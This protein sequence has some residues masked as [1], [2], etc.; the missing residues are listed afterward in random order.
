MGR[1]YEIK[2]D[3]SKF[4]V[5]GRLRKSLMHWKQINAPQFV[6]ETIEF[7]YK[8][9]LLT[10]PPARIFRN[11]KSALLYMLEVLADLQAP[12]STLLCMFFWVVWA[13]SRTRNNIGDQHYGMGSSLGHFI[14]NAIFFV[15]QMN[16]YHSDITQY[17]V[18]VHWYS[19]FKK[20]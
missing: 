17:L 13:K 8:L 2:T 3:V 14:F 11:N 19:N 15:P 5:K 12:V 18:S 6:L 4:S 7:G 10:T 20:T 16:F 9:P 1:N